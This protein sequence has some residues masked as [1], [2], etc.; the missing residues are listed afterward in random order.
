M[1]QN[2]ALQSYFLWG[3]FAE[4]TCYLHRS[5]S[6]CSFRLISFFFPLLDFV[7]PRCCSYLVKQM[8]SDDE[9]ET[10]FIFE[11]CVLFFFLYDV[12][13]F[14]FLLLSHDAHTSRKSGIL[15]HVA[16]CKNKDLFTTL[17]G[18][19]DIS[20]CWTGWVADVRRSQ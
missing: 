20:R 4:V 5:L 1:T 9:G 11:G 18:V 17:R 12:Q 19:C 6:P 2:R 15:E 7:I 3:V 16:R 14:L 13:V 10:I 8:R